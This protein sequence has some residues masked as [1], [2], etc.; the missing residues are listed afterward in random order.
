[1]NDTVWCE[2]QFTKSK[3]V[4]TGYGCQQ[5]QSIFISS[6]GSTC[7]DKEYNRKADVNKDGVINSEDY[8]K[9]WGNSRNETW[10]SW[11]RSNSTNPCA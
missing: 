10:C 11:Q 2:S 6:F 9:I 8:T 4:C 3:D 7:D 5:L 1:M